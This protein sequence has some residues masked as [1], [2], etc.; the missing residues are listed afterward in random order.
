MRLGARGQSA[1]ELAAPGDAP[2]AHRARTAAPPHRRAYATQWRSNPSDVKLGSTVKVQEMAGKHMLE[3]RQEDGAG[4]GPLS[5][6]RATSR[7]L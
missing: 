3:L 5:T 6:V 7:A 1:R 2:D 4:R